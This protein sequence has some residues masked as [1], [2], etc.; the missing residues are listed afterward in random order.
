MRNHFTEL[1]V[2]VQNGLYQSQYSRVTEEYR[3]TT[4]AANRI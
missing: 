1:I 2:E 4:D 3:L